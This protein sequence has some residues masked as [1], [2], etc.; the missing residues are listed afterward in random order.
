[1]RI[2]GGHQDY[3][4]VLPNEKTD[5]PVYLRTRREATLPVVRTVGKEWTPEGKLIGPFVE[6]LMA[7]PRGQ[8]WVA[9][10]T[11]VS[12]RVLLFCGLP[13]AAWN[14]TGVHWVA[15]M[16][17]LTP[18]RGWEK[19]FEEAMKHAP[20]SLSK[21][22]DP[23]FAKETWWRENTPTKEQL[24][25]VHRYY[26]APVVLFSFERWE[27]NDCRVTVNPNI[28]D[29]FPLLMATLP[30]HQ[31]YSEIDMFLGSAL[32]SQHDPVPERTQDLIRDAHGFDTTSFR[33]GADTRKRKQR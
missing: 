13:Y 1:M 26:D 4:E 28:R 11:V 32:V 27:Q 3:Y 25:A 6:W 23:C 12:V 24:V 5:I 17:A 8:M 16:C 31:A 29:T 15:N 22:H 33:K 14:L 30:P 9:G 2:I 7:A 19:K 18:P 20:F 21:G 10:S